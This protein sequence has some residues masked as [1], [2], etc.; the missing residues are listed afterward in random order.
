MDNRI[1]RRSAALLL[2]LV[3]LSGCNAESQQT[4]LPQ[5]TAEAVRTSAEAPA[6]PTAE[7][8][9]PTA[10]PLTGE[11]SVTSEP[12]QS[13]EQGEPSGES[14]QTAE[15]TGQAT[16]ESSAQTAEPSPGE[17]T[18][19]TV[20]APD[21][22]PPETEPELPPET[23]PAETT[24]A[25]PQTASTTAAT[26]AAPPE[27]PA[28]V[29]I[30]D[31]LVP[32]SPGT[33]TAAEGAAV[34]DYSNSS[35]GYISVCWSESG[36]RVKLR[37]TCGDKV[38]DHDVTGGGATDY[39]PVSC[40][41]GEYTVQIYEQTEGNK[42]RKALE[43]QITVKL[44]NDVSPFLY[45]NKYVS[46][47]KKSDC[48]RKAAELCAGKTDEIERLAA[49]FQWITDNV[50][51]DK[52]LAATVQSGYCPDPDKT[53][54][55]KTGICFDYASLMAA[56]ARSQDIPTRLVVGYARDNIYHAWNEVYTSETGWITPELLLAKR[57]YNITDATFYAGS[58][59]KE[60][61]SAY[62]S[63][64]GNYSALYYY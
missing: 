13:R 28:K 43:Q 40:G 27:K 55:K 44:K 34:V 35:D 30:P 1:K 63:D 20:P 25:A 8:A 64:S 49:I 61:I 7:P 24:A 15:P 56:M 3:L 21:T 46:F 36:K 39:F 41:S 59:D 18:A 31:V 23:A 48:V 58:S 60:K 19:E 5:P 17:P 37:L 38:Y 26:T 33:E 29:V 47:T 16:L 32:L 2:A 62:I 50:T 52:Q 9:Q 22:E 14:T 42:Y 4:S 51:Y 12:E 54:G 10:E 45:P 53:L 11:R 6:Q 57:G